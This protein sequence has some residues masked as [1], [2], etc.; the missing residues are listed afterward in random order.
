VPDFADEPTSELERKVSAL[1][2]ACI[3]ETVTF[4]LLQILWLGLHS[5]LGVQ[6]LGSIHGM[7]FLA[8]AAMT[9]G[10]HKPMGWD[11]RYVIIVV[12][13]GPVG[14]VMVYERIR[15]DGVSPEAIAASRPRAGAM[16]PAAATRPVGGSGGDDARDAAPTPSDR[17]THRLPGA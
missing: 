9:Y 13:L 6:L 12:V 5:E 8:F 4:V 10:V 1:K 17:P 14:A 15:R 11:L 2:W 3:I 16:R 7:T